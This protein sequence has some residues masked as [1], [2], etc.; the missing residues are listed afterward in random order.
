MQV[1][2]AAAA[3]EG[4]A[5]LGAEGP[6]T[7]VI[8]PCGLEKLWDR[9]PLAGPTPAKD[10]Y[11]GNLFAAN[12]AFAER[13]GHRWVILSA[14]YGLIDPDF[15]I[16]GPYEVTF[17]D[18]RTRPIAG[19]VLSQQMEAAGF[20]EDFSRVIVLGGREYVQMLRRAFVGFPQIR[21]VF[22]FARLPIGKM[23]QATQRAVR[24][25]SATE[26]WD[27]PEDADAAEVGEAAEGGGDDGAAREALI[28]STLTQS[29]CEELAAVERALLRKRWASDPVAWTHERAR[30]FLWSMQ[31]RIAHSVRDFR[32]TAVKS[33]HGPGKSYIAADIAAWWLDTHAIGE[34]VVVTTAP[35]DRQVRL[36]LWKEIRRIHSRVG[37]A[38]RT[39]QKEWVAA[40]PGGEEE[41]IAFGMHPADYDPTAFQGIH[42]PAVLVI[43]DEAGGI[44]GAVVANRTERP[45]SLWDAADTLLAN[46]NCRELAIGNPDDPSGEFARICK[47]GSGWNVLSISAFDTPNFTGEPVP[48][49]LSLSLVGKTWVEEKRKAWAP[50]WRWNVEGT[51]CLPPE[52]SKL[53]DAHPLWLSKVLG[54]FPENAAA[55]GL[56]PITWVEA[57]LE[58]SLP[59]TEPVELGV[60]MGAGGDASCTAVRRGSVIR[61]LSEDHNPDTMQTC[62]KVVA[63]RRKTCATRVKVD[64][65]GIGQGVVDR[66]LEL[67][68]PFEGVN[69]G[70]AADDPERFLNRRAEL[71]WAVRERFEAGDVDLDPADQATAG[72]L[73]SIRY[74]RNS[75]GQI[76]I[77][78]KESAARRGVPSPNRAEAVM[79]ACAP[80]RITKPRPK[81]GLLF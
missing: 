75:R 50:G 77:E 69:V 57:A 3:N 71:W 27:A 30:G 52:G 58:R 76:V 37:L 10:V 17:K 33:C 29:A 22:P 11:L 32:K 26:Y 35:T 62:G 19:Y 16:P 59:E 15:V 45:Q 7:L 65:I 79:L 46:D 72:E 34:A 28:R 39:N 64:K 70:E 9:Q 13:F 12:R 21:L 2:E 6:R 51:K 20:T 41:I 48:A 44:P 56:L 63:E 61:I 24:A 25:P 42:A 53:E 1:Q 18:R 67:G 81:G 73:C 80:P 36:I 68:E 40:P 14:K 55:Q 23:V 31:K 66:G 8:V 43:L 78:S 38:G 47:P 4:A 49:A 5:S 60:D 54:V 74:T